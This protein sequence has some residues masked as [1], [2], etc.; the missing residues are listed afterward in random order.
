MFFFAPD[1]K[2]LKRWGLCFALVL[3][4]HVAFAA[5]VSYWSSRDEA[6]GGVPIEAM[7]IDMVAMAPA[8][9]PEPL[10]PGPEQVEHKPK[11]EP[12]PEPE[13][14]PDPLALPEPEQEPEE[15]VKE[16]VKESTAPEQLDL[17]TDT[18]KRAPSAE[19]L[20]VMRRAQATWHS[21]LVGHL[22]RHKRYPRSARMRREEGVVH[23]RFRIN[24]DGE[25]LDCSLVTSSGHT[26]LDDATVALVS[27]ASPLPT[28]PDDVPGEV[29]ELVVPVE[30]FLR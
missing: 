19:A 20:G 2:E 8:A 1:K 28:P 26:S 21:R 11:P 7:M 25:V 3:A 24:R 29:H 14:E 9:P 17:P 16:E 22:E 6:G 18:V 13:V 4:L 5:G 12:R 23:V 30:Y 15:E 27:R 10:P